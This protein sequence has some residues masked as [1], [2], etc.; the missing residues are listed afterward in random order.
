[1]LNVI[2]AASSST[3]PTTVEP[4]LT[5]AAAASSRR[6]D[7]PRRSGAVWRVRRRAPNEM[8]RIAMFSHEPEQAARRNRRHA[9][10][11]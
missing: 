10:I 2:T 11:P 7:L 1:M 9:L 6:F 4:M 8:R 3:K 5:R